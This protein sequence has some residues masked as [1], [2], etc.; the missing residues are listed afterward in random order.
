MTTISF[1]FTPMNGEDA[2]AIVCWQYAGPYAVYSMSNDADAARDALLDI[3]SPHF[4]VRDESGELVGFFGYGTAA[5]VGGESEPALWGED[6]CLSVGLGMRPDLTGKGL[7]LAFVEAGL[8]FALQQFAPVSF[9]MFALAW[10][11]RALR[12]YKRAGFVRVRSFIQR[13][14][15][16][17]NEFVEMRRPV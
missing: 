6:R 15:H 14:I 5:E 16:G 1:T 7:G 17:E 12:V 8:D 4:A 10:N 13:N 3:R 2:R 9:L 11:E